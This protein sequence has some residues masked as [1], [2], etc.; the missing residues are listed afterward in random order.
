MHK[1]HMKKMFIKNYGNKERSSKRIATQNNGIKGMRKSAPE[2]ELVKIDK[3]NNN[4]APQE[5]TKNKVNRLRF[6]FHLGNM[7]HLRVE[8]TRGIRPIDLAQF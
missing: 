4:K 1:T 3:H 6:K 7:G 5:T 8:P 2:L